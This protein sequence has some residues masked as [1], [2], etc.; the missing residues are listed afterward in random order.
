MGCHRISPVCLNSC[1]SR[2]WTVREPCGQRTGSADPQPS[3]LASHYPS[4]H[5]LLCLERGCAGSLHHGSPCWCAVAVLHKGGIQVW[6]R[7]RRMLA[8]LLDSGMSLASSIRHQA[9]AVSQHIG[10]HLTPARVCRS[11]RGTAWCP[12]LCCRTF[13]CQTPPAPLTRSFHPWLTCR[14]TWSG[15]SPSKVKPP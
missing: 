11:S 9:L 8:R 1:L 3:L 13:P 7:H 5:V 15:T 4:S 2:P 14:P 10:R 6:C 12:R